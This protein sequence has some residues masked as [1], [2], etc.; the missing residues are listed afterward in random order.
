[1]RKVL[2]AL[3]LTVI[4]VGAGAPTVVAATPAAA[5]VQPG[6]VTLPRAASCSGVWVV[7]DFGSLGGGI[8]NKCATGYDTGLA[9]LR[10]AGFSPT[11]DEGFVYKIS[12][13]P[14]KADINKAYWSY[15]HAAADGNGG[16]S[17]WSYSNL[18]A[19]SYHP[20]QGDAEGWRYVLLSDPRT[21]PQADPPKNTNTSPTP[22]PTKTS[23]RPTPKPSRTT[24][25]PT[26][27]AT[28]SKKPTTATTRATSRAGDATTKAS[29]RKASATTTA[30]KASASTTP[31]TTASGTATA[32]TTDTS[33]PVTGEAT[34]ADGQAT[35]TAEADGSSGS[36][37][38]AI[39]TGAVVVAAAGGL[40][41]W[42]LLK[43]RKP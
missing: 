35:A 20:K 32:T 15:W 18:G 14:G 38:G 6:S 43:G 40:G 11:V 2:A 21:P 37:V 1:M 33:A 30:T 12:G 23:A 17:A 36:P 25:K 22:K 29:T 8:Q 42:W 24:S 41:G 16:Y 39:V 19:G 28:P 26:R 10:S 3:A 27:S 31:T 5:Q 9:A 13:K 4:S 7:V 34:V